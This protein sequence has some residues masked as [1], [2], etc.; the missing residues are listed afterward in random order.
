MGKLFNREKL[1]EKQKLEI[2]KVMLDD[3]N[4]VYVKEMN[5]SDRDHWEASLL[6]KVTKGKEV[7]MEQN[8]ENFRARLVVATVCDE[9]GK[10]LLTPADITT[11]SHNMA[12]RTLEKIMTEAQK[13]N[14]IT[15]E[16][17]EELTKN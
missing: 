9:K 10:L 6:K 2:A 13:L 1:L 17:K 12:A 14:K 3:E 15:E 16:D 4:Y 11:L 5:G 8:L 7:T